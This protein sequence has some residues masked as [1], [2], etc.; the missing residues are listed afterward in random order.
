VP[1]DDF[2]DLLAQADL[3]NAVEH[4]HQRDTLHRLVKQQFFI[5]NS[6]MAFQNNW[7]AFK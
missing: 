2:T 3:Q 4:A 7:R 1:L 5:D 6:W